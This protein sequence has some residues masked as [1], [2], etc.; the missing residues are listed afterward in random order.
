M[1]VGSLLSLVVYFSLW[2]ILVSRMFSAC[3]WIVVS[4]KS[5]FVGSSV[6][7]V[8]SWLLLCVQ[9]YLLQLNTT[10]SSC[11][12]IQALKGYQTSNTPCESFLLQQVMSPT[13]LWVVLTAAV[14]LSSHYL[15]TQEYYPLQFF[16][17]FRLTAEVWSDRRHSIMKLALFNKFL[18]N[19][20]RWWREPSAITTDY[21]FYMLLSVST[22]WCQQ[23]LNN[24]NSY[25]NK[26]PSMWEFLSPSNKGRT[27]STL[28]VHMG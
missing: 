27:T 18:P 26:S 1:V 25:Y 24:N 10:T 7:R 8:I 11:L 21:S 4:C 19:T 5:K 13:L 15:T 9:I 17:H 3:H 2:H 22:S 16:H 14:N 23:G 6:L 12:Q 20:W 28:L